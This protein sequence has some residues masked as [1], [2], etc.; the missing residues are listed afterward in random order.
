[1][2][3]SALL[4]AMISPALLA[5]TLCGAT[6]PTSQPADAILSE[7]QS[8]D[9]AA[10]SGPSDAGGA[11]SSQSRSE[12]KAELLK[13]LIAAN[14]ESPE[15]VR[16]LAQRWHTMQMAGSHRLGPEIDQAIQSSQSPEVLANAYL[17][18]FNMAVFAAKNKAGAYAT[19]RP[20]AEAY[21]A[22]VPQGDYLSDM[23][24]VVADNAP[25][26]LTEAELLRK[27]VALAK[28]PLQSERATA[29]LKSLDAY[30]KPL[31]L[32]FADVISGKQIRLQ[33]LRGKVVVLDFWATWCGPCKAEMP[34][35]KKLY[36]AYKDK[37]VQF[38][39]ITLDGG[40]EEDD[41]LARVKAYV[42]ANDITWPQ[43]YQGKSWDADF[44]GS[45]GVMS[46]PT[47]FVLDQKGNVRSLNADGSLD[48]LLPSLLQESTSSAVKPKQG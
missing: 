42:T 9:H 34:A 46:L 30:G 2:M 12:R 5:A 17:A 29:R 32:E 36:A 19:L 27:S 13:E 20:I 45:L 16:Y 10:A 40:E 39:G 23:Y 28:E 4:A 21:A 33:D 43:Y 11:S 31:N 47:I 1:M 24:Y 44:S 14:P 15:A 26:P 18:K 37:G 35:M 22:R 48:T 7:I 38:I 25:D 8:L 6:A 3:K 41:G